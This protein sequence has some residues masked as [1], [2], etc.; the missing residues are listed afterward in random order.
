MAFKKPR[1]LEFPNCWEECPFQIGCVII[2]G[3]ADVLPGNL[4][5][6]ELPAISVEKALCREND[7]VALQWSYPSFS[8]NQ[9]LCFLSFP[10]LKLRKMTSF[11]VKRDSGNCDCFPTFAHALLSVVKGHVVKDV[12]FFVPPEHFSSL[13]HQAF[14]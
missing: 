1:C 14:L 8:K 7:K 10:A 3:K 13:L 11:Q 12:E 6:I 2:S 4:F 9:N 5:E